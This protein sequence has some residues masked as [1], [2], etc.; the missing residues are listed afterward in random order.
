MDDFLKVFKALSDGTRLKIID[1]LL[2]H[3]FCV[4]AL[5][6]KLGISEAAVSQHLQVL[7]K[8]GLVSGEKRGYYTHYDLNRELFTQAASAL[9]DI[10]AYDAPRKGC[11]QH[12]TGDH[13]HCANKNPLEKK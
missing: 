8:A 9:Q 13:Q 3:D 2:K 5:S 10:V 1:L 11:R 7:R 4:G 6:R 12:L